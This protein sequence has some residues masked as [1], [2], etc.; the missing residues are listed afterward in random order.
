MN[1]HNRT[2]HLAV[3]SRQSLSLAKTRFKLRNEG[4]YLGIFWYLLEPLSSFIILLFLG[5]AIQHTTIPYYPVY[6]LLGLTMF[7]FFS[8]VTTASTTAI[9]SN[10]AFIKSMKISKEPFV[11]SAL[12][13]YIFS[14]FFEVLILMALAAYL[15]L[16]LSGFLFYPV[17]FVF[18]CFFILGCS[19]ILATIGVYI[20]DLSNI[21]AILTR[22]LW[23]STP[24]FYSLEHVNLLGK[25]NS[26]NFLYYFL[27]MARKSIIAQSLPE[28]R[29]I[30]C[31]AVVGL[32][33]FF[34]GLFIFQKHQ[35]QFAERL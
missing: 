34:A 23:F 13:Q 27:S 15:G 25:F 12:I 20:R 1:W 28:V 18:F 33:L 10:A 11:I 5:R 14:H 2:E 6:L 8:A 21:W 30:I 7:N 29:E 19:F 17:I 22:L 3:I 16:P 9:V 31:G 32:V 4:S 35:R 26:F 24:I